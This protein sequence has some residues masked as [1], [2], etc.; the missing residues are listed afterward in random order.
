MEEFK[1]QKFIN[2]SNIIHNFLY[3]YSATIFTLRKNNV[4]IICKE[5]GLFEQKATNHLA[6]RGCK[7]CAR[8]DRQKCFQLSNSEFINRCKLIH[9]DRYNYDQVQYIN[10]HTPV[11]ILCN[12]HGIFEQKPNSH[13]RGNGCSKCN[14]STGEYYIKEI[15]DSNNIK[16]VTEKKFDDCKNITFLRFDF[17]LIDFNICIEYDGK[18]H[19]QESKLFGGKV[20]FEKRQINDMI[21]ND[22]C[23]EYDIKLIRFSYKKSLIDIKKE[24]ENIWKN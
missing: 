6:G 22:F 12:N 1:T 2:S 20:D 17:Y 9:G 8:L 13:F 15:L 21:K 5:H 7:K 10:R 14:C 24:L 4:K 3:D 11:K 19:F 18:Q 23:K 16:Y